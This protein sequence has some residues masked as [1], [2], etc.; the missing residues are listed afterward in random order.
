MSFPALI[1]VPTANA[2][3]AKATYTALLGIEPYVDSEY[4]IGYYTDQGEIGIDPSNPGSGPLPYWDVADMDAA[5][6]SLTA[7][8][9]TIVK[10]PQEV[11]GGL[12]VAVLADSDGNPIG[13]RQEA[14]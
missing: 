11:G 4:Y 8:G 6:A 1:V 3:A 13:L 5:I 12:T 10:A 14:S 9:A 2:E 7:T